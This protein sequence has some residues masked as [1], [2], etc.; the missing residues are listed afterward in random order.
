MVP[1]HLLPDMRDRRIG[2]LSRVVALRYLRI[3]PA[4]STIRYKSTKWDDSGGL[5]NG[6]G[7]DADASKQRAWPKSGSITAM[8]I[9][10]RRISLI[11]VTG[12]L[13]ALTTVTI[14]VAANTQAP[15]KMPADLSTASR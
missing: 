8:R 11:I 7:I 9:L 6:N 14:P 5:F 1:P 10:Q 12:L 3:Y 13:A 15:R 2:C 4:M